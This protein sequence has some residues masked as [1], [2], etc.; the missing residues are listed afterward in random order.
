MKRRKLS[1]NC[2]VALL[3]LL[4]LLSCNNDKD[5]PSVPDMPLAPIIGEWL[6]NNS[7][8][9]MI[10]LSETCYYSDDTMHVQTVIV[11]TEINEIPE[12]E[13]TWSKSDDQLTEIYESPFTGETTTERYRIM[14][15]D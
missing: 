14:H 11:N 6:E 15:C 10:G 1:K 12:Y 4:G 2:V 13:G 3:P 9:K 7:D 5:E 8:D